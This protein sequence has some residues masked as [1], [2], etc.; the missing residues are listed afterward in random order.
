MCPFPYFLLRGAGPGW[1]LTV[2]AGFADASRGR[3]WDLGTKTDTLMYNHLLSPQDS[4]FP[5]CLPG[6]APTELRHH[7]GC[8]SRASHVHLLASPT[9]GRGKV[10]APAG[11]MRGEEKFPSNQS[12]A[13]EFGGAGAGDTV[14]WT[15]LVRCRSC[16]S[17]LRGAT[18]E[19]GWVGGV[20]P[21][22]SAPI[23]TPPLPAL[24]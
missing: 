15:D 24:E 11:L 8:R 23:C 14:S 19:E 20:S 1:G 17:V 18:C 12:P 7:L 3:N 4:P 13:A 21:R 10:R 6:A 22:L 16:S 5:I 9:V 2:L